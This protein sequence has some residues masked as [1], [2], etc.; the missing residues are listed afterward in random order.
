[1]L[2]ATGRGMQVVKPV[3]SMSR[4]AAWILLTVLVMVR[5]PSLVQP[6]G[7]DQDLYAYVGQEISRGGLPYVDA[8]D[9]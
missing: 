9:Q 3:L 5:L 8:W 2:A 1:V 7:A 6:A 4:R